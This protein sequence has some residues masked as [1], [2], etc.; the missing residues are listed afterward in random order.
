MMIL[1][2]WD[3]SAESSPLGKLELHVVSVA[4]EAPQTN[5]LL[6]ILSRGAWVALQEAMVGESLM[7]AFLV[8]WR[9]WIYAGSGHL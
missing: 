8:A 2:V 4:L 6:G 3:I 9:D 1:S 7:V 5:P